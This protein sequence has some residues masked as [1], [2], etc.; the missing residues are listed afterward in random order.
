MR[1]ML[2][3]NICSYVLRSRPAS[4]RDRF[5]EAGPE[6]LAISAVVLAE[7]LFGAARH[8]AEAAIRREIGDF[9]SRLTVLSWDEAA[10]EHY[11]DIRAALEGRGRPL[12]AMDLHIA[13]HARSRGATLVSS[14]GR[15]FRRVE[16]LLVANWV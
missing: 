13:A 16:G 6:A 1:Y 7:L 8:P 9:V 4:V 12:G 14:D 15:H 11:G 10:A 3:T 5:D 2:D